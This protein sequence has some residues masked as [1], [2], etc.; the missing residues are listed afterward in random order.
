MIVALPISSTLVLVLVVSPLLSTELMLHSHLFKMEI[1]KQ[2]QLLKSHNPSPEK[3]VVP[4]S[5]PFSLKTLFLSDLEKS[6]QQNGFTEPY[7]CQDGAFRN[8]KNNSA[9]KLSCNKC[10]IFGFVFS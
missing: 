3:L 5:P 7:L 6:I 9:T 8:K 2:Q 4:N 10:Y 1:L